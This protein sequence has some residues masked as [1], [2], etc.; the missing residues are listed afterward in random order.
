[1]LLHLLRITGCM[2]AALAV[3]AGC[4]SDGQARSDDGPKVYTASQI[5]QLARTRHNQLAASDSLGARVFASH[6]AR[7]ELAR[8]RDVELPSYDQPA[9]P[10]TDQPVY[11]E[12][13]V[14]Q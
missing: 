7:V 5:E 10:T 9:E 14:D 6:E 8:L 1:M 4:Q 11:A 12:V 13:P 3:V 2:V